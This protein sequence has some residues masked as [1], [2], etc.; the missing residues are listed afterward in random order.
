MRIYELAKELNVKSKV[1]VDKCRAKGVAVTSHMSGIDDA[2]VQ[3]LRRTYGGAAPE[4][5][6]KEPKPRAEKPPAKR[7]PA[8]ERARAPSRR[9][10]AKPKPKAKP[11]REPAKAVAP[12]V[13]AEPPPN[14]DEEMAA[15]RARIRRHVVPPKPPVHLRPLTV[16]TPTLRRPAASPAAGPATATST[17]TGTSTSAPSRPGA[18]GP[19]EYWPGLDTRT[20][21]QYR[22]PS[23]RGR[24]R[25]RGA[26]YRPV[27]KPDKIQVTLPV[28][29]KDLSSIMA[30]KANVLMGQLMAKGVMVRLNDPID[31]ETVL[32]LGVE[33]SIEIEITKAR[34]LEQE[35]LADKPVDQEKERALRPPIV[36]LLGHVDHGKTSLL[37][38]IRQANVVESE[39]GGIT[40][41][42]GAYVVEHAGRKITFL[43]TPGHEAFTAMR[44][45][46]AHV[47]DIVVLV[48]AADDGVMPQTE[49]A[50]SHARAAEVPIVV[51]LN[52]MDKPNANPLRSHQQLASREL[53]PE[54]WGGQTVFVEVSATT[55]QGLPELL[56]FLSL[57][58]ELLELKANRNKQASGVILEARLSDEQGVMATALVR[59]GT[60]RVGDDMI[61]GKSFGRVRAL[62]SDKG[63]AVEEAGP[64]MPVVVCGLSEVPEAGSQ[65]HIVEDTQKIR[66][67][68][69]D[70]SRR[71]R[72]AA[73]AER[74]SI[75]LENLYNVIAQDKLKEILLVL[76]ADVKGSLEVM[77]NSLAELSISEVKLRVLHAGV[78]GINESDVLLADASRAI[79]LGFHVEPEEKARL[80]AQDKDVEI[81]TYTVIHHAL[82]DIRK[83]LEGLLEPEQVEQVTG[84]LVVRDTFKVSRIGTVA[85][86]YVTEGRVHRNHFV[87][88]VRDSV[89]I[90]DRGKLSSLRRF[91]DDA[92][93]VQAGLEC[94]V[95][96]LGYDDLKI[97]D[98]IVAYE[99][100]SI[101][102]TLEDAS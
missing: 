58:A 7:A 101:A 29:V 21:P 45:R 75:T 24:P 67:V 98:E 25:Q 76:K 97:G 6:V 8:A 90:Y 17:G 99:I 13:P 65:F 72:E 56:E 40:Q 14:L 41:H 32:H 20:R 23:R 52:K 62:F 95:K 11:E 92:R 28:T 26:S 91:K 10:T 81:R 18:Q 49:E 93:E 86:C 54:D 84:R 27:V 47:T 64:S 31:E 51:A 46:G 94:G 55:G 73:L 80:L 63:A 69:L 44:A 37:D 36:T 89:P 96:I 4:P 77:Q 3:E 35:L 19:R 88:L 82:D 1:L 70:R 71:E 2:T 60:L 61:C 34:D 68:A 12:E 102:R 66:D 33:N 78:G 48:V 15:R 85:G 30:L 79:V 59:D 38:A 22:R 53:T 43:D 57:E 39:S 87:R 100:Q 42:I 9:P 5:V 50:I 83:A 74:Q 16:A